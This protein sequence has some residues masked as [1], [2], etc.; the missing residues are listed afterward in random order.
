M[1]FQLREKFGVRWKLDLKMVN[2]LEILLGLVYILCI[3]HLLIKIKHGL[4]E[5]KQDKVYG[6]NLKIGGAMQIWTWTVLYVAKTEL[7]IDTK[8]YASIHTVA[9]I[10][11]IELIQACIDTKL[12]CIDT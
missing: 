6:K 12:L 3:N 2:P 4:V 8:D 5:I 7:C 9:L 1:K 10:N 11:F